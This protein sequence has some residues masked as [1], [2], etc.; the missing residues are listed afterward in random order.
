MSLNDNSNIVGYFRIL[1]DIG[2][3]VCEVYYHYAYVYLCM[4]FLIN[5]N[6]VFMLVLDLQGSHKDSTRDPIHPIP[7]FS[8]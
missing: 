6:T 2:M 8:Y 5:F 1:N 3:T 4:C 7:S